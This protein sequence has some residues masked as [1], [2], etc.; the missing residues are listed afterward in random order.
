M[1]VVVAAASTNSANVAVID[2]GNTPPTSVM[3]PASSAGNVVDCY[4]TL[5]AIGDCGG[6]SVTLYDI[7]NPASPSR[8]GSANTGLPGITAISI[9]DKYVLAGGSNGAL[10]LVSIATPSSPSV[11]STLTNT[12]SPT[13][14]SVVVRGTNAVAACTGQFLTVDYTHPAHPAGSAN[15]GGANPNFDL[16]GQTL[17]DFDGTNA[18]VTS[19]PNPYSLEVFPP[20]YVFSIAQGAPTQ[21]AALQ[22]VGTLSSVAI[23]EIP[24]GGYYVAT[25]S[26]S[27][28]FS[29]QAFPDNAP[30]GTLTAFA[31]QFGTP[32]TGVALKFLNNPAEAPFLAVANVTNEQGYWI[33]S[34]LLF[35]T[36]GNSTGIQIGTPIPTIQVM[37]APTLN[38]TLGITAF[39]PPPP[40]WRFPIPLPPWLEKW[41]ARLLGLGG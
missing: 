10:V 37:L 40:P 34:N 28:E 1:P 31:P 21:I 14:W 9:D 2:F 38:P 5:A 23:A 3:L 39:T 15:D 17:T 12:G 30:P 33:S 27:G 6:G 29:I 18:V 25:A 11:V 35:L 16:T 36:T 26:P 41:L 19:G 8:L 32:A 13:I 20:I 4:G 24:D 7:T 22:D